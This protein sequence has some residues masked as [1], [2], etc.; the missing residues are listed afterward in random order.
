MKAFAIVLS[1]MECSGE[2]MVGGD[3]TNVQCKA[4]KNC[5][6]ESSLH[7]KHTLTKNENK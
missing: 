5:L 1:E 4:I 7:N 3:L 2:E 6:S